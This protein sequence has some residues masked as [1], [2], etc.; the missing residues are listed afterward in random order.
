MIPILVGL[1]LLEN[2]AYNEEDTSSEEILA[3]KSRVSYLEDN[4][5][6]YL[7][8]PVMSEFSTN[9][10]F[11]CLQEKIDEGNCRAILFDLSMVQVPSIIVRKL[12][13]KRFE[14]ISRNCDLICFCTGKSS[15]IN[16][17]LKFFINSSDATFEDSTFVKNKSEAL[18][19]IYEKLGRK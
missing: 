2:R 10:L 11:D 16:I 13:Y 9:L 18:E 17:A 4:I 5:V 19:Y 6:Q 14:M 7:E 1:F 15:L 8:L 12:I 3:I